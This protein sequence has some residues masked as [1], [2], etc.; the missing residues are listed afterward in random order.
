MSPRTIR[1]QLIGEFKEEYALVVFGYLFLFV[2][3]A[4]A[5]F[6]GFSPAWFVVF[7]AV[8][9]AGYLFATAWR[10]CLFLKKSGNDVSRAPSLFLKTPMQAVAAV[11]SSFVRFFKTRKHVVATVVGALILATI[12]VVS[13]LTFV[14][15][16]FAWIFFLV[17][18][19]AAIGCVLKLF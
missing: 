4:V 3:P 14:A 8:G 16:A 2:S 10:T 6:S 15:Y 19:C 7:A 5:Y 1:G 9:V 12:A 13:I 11:Y 17:C 18:A